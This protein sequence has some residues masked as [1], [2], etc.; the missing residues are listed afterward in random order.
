MKFKGT[1]IITDPCYIMRAKHH[2]TTPITKDDWVACDCGRN[3][4]VLGIKHYICE[5]TI[6]GD[7]SCRT[8]KVEGNPKEIID[9]IVEAEENDKD[10][11]VEC[12]YLGDFCADV[13]LV[14]VFLLDEVRKY[15]PDI[16]KWITEHPWC[17]TT[18]EDFDGEVEYYVDKNKNAHIYGIGNI[19][20]FTHF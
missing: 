8:Y 3:M 16:D 14:S 7:W 19:N 18:I 13:G 10:Y 20:F 15:N 4:E 17:V 6:W 5:S 11:G 12:S 9:N 1:I 2:G